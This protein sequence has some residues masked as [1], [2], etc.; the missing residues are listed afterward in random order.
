MT[1][2]IGF[3]W[4]CFADAGKMADL[5]NALLKQLLYSFWPFGNWLCFAQKELICRALST[6]VEHVDHCS[7]HSEYLAYSINNWI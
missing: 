2:E 7:I 5:Y 6:K 1:F 4:L 3:V